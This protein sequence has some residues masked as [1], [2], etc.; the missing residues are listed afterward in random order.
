[1]DNSIENTLFDLRM[2]FKRI[3][4]NPGTHPRCGTRKMARFRS[5]NTDSRTDNA[6]RQAFG[7]VGPPGEATVLVFE[8]WTKRIPS[9]VRPST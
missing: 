6:S 9:H 5:A 7:G 2:L 1:M 3:G 4:E 8:T